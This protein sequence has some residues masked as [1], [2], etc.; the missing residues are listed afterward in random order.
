MKNSHS[1]SPSKRLAILKKHTIHST[2]VSR[3]Y[4]AVRGGERQK[5]EGAESDPKSG[6]PLL[7]PEEFLNALRREEDK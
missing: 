1:K 6:H 4:V 2:K 5:P 7:D 3:R